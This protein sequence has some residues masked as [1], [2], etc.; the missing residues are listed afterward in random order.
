MTVIFHGMWRTMR[1]LYD[2]NGDQPMT[3]V[4]G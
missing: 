2:I 3:N 1:E 4:M